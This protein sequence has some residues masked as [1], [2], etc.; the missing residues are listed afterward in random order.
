MKRSLKIKAALVVVLSIW[1]LVSLWP[2]IQ[3]SR[4]SPE[5]RAELEATPE[6][7]AKLDH[8]HG[9]AIKRGLDLQGGMYL[10][11]DV[12]TKSVEQGTSDD[13]V[14]R[15][16][17]ILRNRIDQFGVSEPDVRQEGTSRIIVQLPGLQDAERAKRLIG[18]TARLEFRMVREGAEVTTLIARLDKALAGKKVAADALKSIDEELEAADSTEVEAAA[19]SAGVETAEAAGDSAQGDLL[20]DLGGEGEETVPGEGDWTSQH[21][22]SALMGPFLKNRGAIPVADSNRPAVEKLL[23]SPEAQRL[24]PRDVEFLWGSEKVTGTD[25]SSASLLYLVEKKIELT[26]GEIRNAGVSPDPDRPPL[27]MVNLGLSKRGGLKFANVTGANVGRKLAIVL[28]GVVISA[29]NIRSIIRCRSETTVTSAFE[30]EWAQRMSLTS[31]A[32]AGPSSSWTPSRSRRSSR[33]VNSPATVT[34]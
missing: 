32:A 13:A 11:L 20:S 8:L 26:G 33:Q 1:A 4:M 18:R 5:K 7:A 3:L 28:D 29:P 9:R 27:L 10:V 6:G 16:L 24:I 30:V 12:D 14:K 34:R 23:Q 15:T 17:E 19:D 2:T 31:T 25:G 21:P 22:L